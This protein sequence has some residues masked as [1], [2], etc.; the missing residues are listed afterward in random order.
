MNWFVDEGSEGLP[1][2]RQTAWTS[3]ENLAVK[4][5]ILLYS[6]LECRL[7]MRHKK[8]WGGDALKNVPQATNLHID[9][10]YSRK[11]GQST[12]HLRARVDVGSDLVN[13]RPL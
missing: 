10:R 5:L 13:M 11:I 12:V 6:E 4:S 3:W 8:V 1:S 7:E 2:G 9:S